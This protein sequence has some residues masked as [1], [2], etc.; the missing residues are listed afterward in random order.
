[1]QLPRFAGMSSSE[2]SE[3]KYTSK[4]ECVDLE[5]SA[6]AKLQNL[7][8]VLSETRKLLMAENFAQVEVL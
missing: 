2:L 1:M 3:Y 7:E 8:T 4:G 6:A 5:N